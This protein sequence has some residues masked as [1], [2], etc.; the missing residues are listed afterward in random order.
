MRCLATLYLDASTGL[1]VQVS[2]EHS[3]LINRAEVAFVQVLCVSVIVVVFAAQNT[4]GLEL[5]ST[6]FLDLVPG[7]FDKHYRCGEVHTE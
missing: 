6:L 4:I 3:Y 1:P 2:P 7:A 5:S